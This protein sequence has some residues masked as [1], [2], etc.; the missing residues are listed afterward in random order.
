MNYIPFISI[1]TTIA[2]AILG[3]N[4]SAINKVDAKTEANTKEI[5]TV[6]VDVATMQTDL[7]YIIQG[8]DA[9]NKK[10]K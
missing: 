7:K 10:V 6:R 5:I 9:L 1:A 3:Y 8:I 2:L 4:S